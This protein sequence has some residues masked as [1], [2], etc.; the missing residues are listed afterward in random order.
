MSHDFRIARKLAKKTR[1]VL[2]PLVEK[3][4][5]KN[6]QICYEQIS[7]LKLKWFPFLFE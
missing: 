3:K 1:E 7:I 5:L 6:K 4:N 2:H